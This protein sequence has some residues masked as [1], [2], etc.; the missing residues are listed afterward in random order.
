MC[1][2]WVQRLIR[3]WIAA[4]PEYHERG[5]EHL[6]LLRRLFMQAAHASLFLRPIAAR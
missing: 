1:L 3:L 4:A 2:A 6:A 5:S